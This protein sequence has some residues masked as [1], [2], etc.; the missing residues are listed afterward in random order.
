MIKKIP[1]NSGQTLFELVISIA[2]G[3]VIVTAVLVLTTTSVKNSNFAKT[4][5]QAT[6]YS[7][8][9]LE[10]VR[11]ERDKDWSVFASKSGNTAQYYCLT[12]LSWPQSSG[13]CLSSQYIPNTTFKREISLTNKEGLDIIEVQVVVSW[14]DGTGSHESKLSTQL[15]N[16]VVQSDLTIPPVVYDYATGFS[17]QQ[18][19]IWYYYT[20]C[21]VCNPHSYLVPAV[22]DE[23]AYNLTDFGYLQDGPYWRASYGGNYQD[24]LT[25]RNSIGGAQAASGVVVYWKAP[26]DGIADVVVTDQRIRQGAS[27]TNGY[28]FGFTYLPAALGFSYPLTFDENEHTNKSQMNLKTLSRTYNVLKNDLIVYYKDSIA[29][30]TQ[31]DWANF[32][33]V[34]TLRP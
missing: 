13:S 11:K 4:N 20:V 14:V 18:G 26:N 16:W 19:P 28:N 2:L 24:L 8:G 22:Y 10:W 6:R 25:S 27:W 30:D 12:S 1:R 21:L 17:T 29:S 9:S 7:Q 31:D 15:T 33:I 23:G 3:V 32:T 34:I 5:A